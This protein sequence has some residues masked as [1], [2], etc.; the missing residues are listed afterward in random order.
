MLLRFLLVSVVTSLG[1][2]APTPTQMDC[3]TCQALTCW[4]AH[5]EC[6]AV[7]NEVAPPVAVVAELP[8]PAAANPGTVAEETLA[9]MPD[10]S[11]A[12]AAEAVVETTKAVA[13]VPAEVLSPMPDDVSAFLTGLFEPVPTESTPTT[14]A[15]LA[16][17][18]DDAAAFAVTPV[19]TMPGGLEAF[20]SDPETAQPAELVEAV[21]NPADLEAFFAEL[22]ADPVSV[23]YP[24]LEHELAVDEPTETVV[25][26]ESRIEI[27]DDQPATAEA[28]PA[29]P[30]KDG[31]LSEAVRLTRQAVRAWVGVL[32]TPAVVAAGR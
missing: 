32:N 26:T 16:P 24:A 13:E 19:E 3:W 5:A 10:D 31:K 18:P 27:L 11:A 12:F 2:D 6:S 23:L 15:A 28:V 25:E 1:M 8:E 30:I 4:D 14:E 20:V 29:A 9:P 7:P 22:A 21:A 17:M